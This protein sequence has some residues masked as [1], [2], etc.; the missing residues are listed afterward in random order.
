MACSPFWHTE[1]DKH[2]HRHR[3][4]RHQWTSSR[5]LGKSPTTIAS[6]AG[7]PINQ[8]VLPLKEGRPQMEGKGLLSYAH[9]GDLP[10]S[11]SES[12]DSP[13]AVIS[14][15][16]I[17]S[18]G[19]SQQQRETDR[20]HPWGKETSALLGTIPPRSGSH[21]QTHGSL[22]GCQFCYHTKGSTYSPRDEAD[23]SGS[24]MVVEKGLY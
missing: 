4:T 23:L 8:M 24:K 11:R 10:Y 19:G 22:R 3:K 18:I 5:I 2:T 6:L 16:I 20:D 14:L 15:S 9:R 12:V 7:H 13:E 21:G 17:E 1:I